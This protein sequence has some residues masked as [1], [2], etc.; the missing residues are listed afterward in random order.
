MRTGKISQFLNNRLE[1]NLKSLAVLIDPDKVETEIELIDLVNSYKSGPVDLFLVGGSLLS[2]NNQDNVV[3]AIKSVSDMPVILFPG[4]YMY[5]D[6]NAD[7]ILF[8]SLISGRNPEFLIGQHV[9]AAPLLKNSNVEVLPTGYMLI[10]DDHKTTVAYISN[11]TPIPRHK[12]S[13]AVCTAMAGE[14]LGLKMIYLDAG[15][16]AMAPVPAKMIR[17]VKSA[18]KLPLIVGGGINTL[19]KANEALASGADML[20]IGNGLENQSGFLSELTSLMNTFND[21]LNI[22]Q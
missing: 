11:T 20:V 18:I 19:H 6:L 2:S 13:I 1:N 7:G 12:E 14:M 10:G 22:H 21:T 3:K 4:S 15:S 9:V 16:G 5:V 17:A 8:L